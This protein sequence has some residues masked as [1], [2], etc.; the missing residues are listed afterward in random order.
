VTNTAAALPTEYT[1]FLREIFPNALIYRMYGLTECKRVSYLEPE[2]LDKKPNSVGKAIPGT[3]VFILNKDEKLVAPGQQGILHVRGPHIMAGYWNQPEKTNKMLKP[4]LI[5]GEKILCTQDMFWMDKEGFLYFVTRN[6]E[7]IKTRGEKVS[8]IEVE[9]ILYGM[10]DVEAAAVI[11]VRDKT[12]GQAIHAFLVLTAGIRLTERQVQKRCSE[13]MES[14]MVP[15]RIFFL[16]ELPKSANGKI[17]KL[18]LTEWNGNIPEKSVEIE[19]THS[20]PVS[21]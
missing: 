7:I 2:L 19:E 17:D 18:V 8:P 1:P 14:F 5:P 9:N 6:D 3:E 21:A 13:K 10:E 20:Y 15:T 16:D 12:L 11:G 4:G